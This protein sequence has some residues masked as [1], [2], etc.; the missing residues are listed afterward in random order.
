MIAQV[1]PLIRLP[2]SLGVFTYR[3]PLDLTKKICIGQLATINFREKNIYGLIIGLD[4][5]HQ[6][7]K[8]QLKPINKIIAPN[9]LVTLNQIKLIDFIAKTYGLSPGLVA[10]SLVPEIPRKHK[11][12]KTFPPEADQPLAE[13]QKNSQ[14]LFWYQD[15]KDV[16]NLIKEKCAAVLNNKKQML[17]LV[18][19]INLID[20]IIKESGLKENQII[21]I[22]SRLKK[23]EYFKD[24]Q[25]ILTGQAKIII[26]TKIAVLLPFNN[27][28]IIIVFNE[29]DWNHKQSDINPRYDVRVIAKWLAKNYG[30][31]LILA[32]PAPAVE[33][34]FKNK[35]KIQEH[36]SSVILAQA[37]ISWIFCERRDP[38]LHGEVFIVDLNQERLAGNY[39]FISD[40]LLDKIKE[41]LEAKQ[42]IFLFHNRTGFAKFI[43]CHDCQY[44]FQCPK[45]ETTLNYETK[46]KR[47]TCNYCGYEEDMPPLCPKCAGADIKF[48]SAG[49]QKIKSE[50]VKLLPETNI[51]AMEKTSKDIDVNNINI[52]IG[53]KFALNKINLKN[54]G[55]IAFINFDQLLN[56]T[57]FRASEKAYQLFYELKCQ[58]Q[59][60]DFLIQTN[61]QEN[62][63]IKS[64]AQDNPALFYEPEL[65][66]RAELNYPPACQLIKLTSQN[67]TAKN[68]ENELKKTAQK[69]KEKFQKIEILGPVA[70]TPY[71]VRGLYKYH[72][73]L[74][75]DLK[76]NMEQILTI[77]PDNIIIDVNPEK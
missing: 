30:S 28:Q 17:I 62:N 36:F 27:L 39:S 24:W 13:K 33:T 8:F 56:I 20:K 53:T 2:K 72:L 4:K 51:I 63:V 68:A 40:K 60:A 66:I 71:K 52:V 16:L 21:K 50:L 42:K 15:E 1:L 54:F 69:I 58:N 34:Y 67:K 18:P 6:K 43:I 14:S 9:V 45:C 23:T 57:D 55:L 76:L 70:N 12:I 47:L 19:E 35:I 77:V 11:N 29:H 5:K 37:R 46:N 10:K 48:K 49:V 22:H 74:K 3:V 44:V 38:R 25:K 41:K 65:K 31:E 32:T 59:T 64:I 73:L 61:T 75:I 7:I 26:G